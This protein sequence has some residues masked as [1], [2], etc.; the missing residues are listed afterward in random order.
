MNE[1]RKG[2]SGWLATLSGGGVEREA[3]AVIVMMQRREVQSMYTEGGL[4]EF[5]GM[6]T[7][8]RWGNTFTR[9]CGRNS[10]SGRL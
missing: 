3:L 5:G 4:A 9:C 7:F 2:M 8:W 6:M 10:W 1:G